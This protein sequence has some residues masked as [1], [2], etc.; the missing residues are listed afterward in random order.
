MPFPKDVVAQLDY[1]SRLRLTIC[2]FRMKT[3]LRPEDEDGEHLPLAGLDDSASLSGAEAGTCEQ[4][5]QGGG[6]GM[7]RSG[8]QSTCSNMQVAR[9]TNDVRLFKPGMLQELMCEVKCGCLFTFSL[10]LS[11]SLSVSLSVSLSFLSFSLSYT[12][13]NASYLLCTLQCIPDQ[14]MPL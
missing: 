11:L 1:N 10:S 3:L 7:E 2:F 5:A 6:E 8:D 14:H 12:E 9:Q 4:G 13:H